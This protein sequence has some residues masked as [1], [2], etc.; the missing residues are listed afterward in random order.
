MKNHLS[1]SAARVQKEKEQR[2]NSILEAAKK[3]FFKVGYAKATMDDIAKFAEI[4]K[5]TV[6][7]YFRSKDELFFSLMLPLIDTI[8]ERLL[9]IKTEV[10]LNKITTIK[11]LFGRIYDQLYTIYLSDPGSFKIIIVFQ[12]QSR[13][14]LALRVERKSIIISKVK[15]FYVHF[16]ALMKI[17]IDHNLIKPVDVYQITDLLWINFSGIIQMKEYKPNANQHV[18]DMLGFS[19]QV[20]INYL[21]I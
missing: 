19:K 1:I 8:Q 9:E 21:K 13:L 11:Q 20:I 3:V 16:R 15:L 14:V 2:R 6:Y 12:Q 5:P 17:S 18:K 7:Q 4:T 10:S